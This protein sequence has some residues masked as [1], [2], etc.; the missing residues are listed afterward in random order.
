M[1]KGKTVKLSVLICLALLQTGCKLSFLGRTEIDQIDFIRVVGIDKSA[2]KEDHVRLTIATQKIQAESSGG[3]SKKQ[4]SIVVSEGETVF[5]AVRNFWSYMDNRPFWGHIGYTLIGEE[6]AKDGIMKYIDFFCRDPEVRLN[7]E[8]FQTKGT[9]AEEVII[10]ATGENR[11]IFEQLEGI[12]ENQSGQSVINVVNLVEVMYILDKGYLSLYIPCLE[13][14]QKTYPDMQNDA[15]DIAMGGF[16]LFEGD[17]LVAH[18]NADMGRGLNW[19][20]NKVESGVI[21][22]KSPKGNSV[23]LEIIE[24]DVKLKPT[25]VN[26]KLTVNVNVFITCSI[27]GLKGAEDVFTEEAIGYLEK[28]LKENVKSEIEDVIRF[29]Q[30]N[31]LDII[32]VGDAVFHKYP[33]QWEDD[34]EKKWKSFFPEITYKVEV[35]PVIIGTYNIIQP[36]MIRKDEGP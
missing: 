20:K 28:Q 30:E 25:L 36:N 29:S 27:G 17:K 19:L 7:M 8:I 22:V 3:G 33:I 11:F 10:K 9:T 5:D 1:R 12:T 21:V 31:N 24:N 32:G 16:A 34:L 15:M 23:S 13:I 26:Q 18:L 14:Q 2:E 4:S 35:T 6:A